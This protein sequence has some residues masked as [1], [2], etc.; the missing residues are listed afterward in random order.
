[1]KKIVIIVAIA[2][3]VTIAPSFV[4]DMFV[5]TV[6]ASNT[7]GT[8]DAT[9]KY[10]WGENIGWINF[11]TT[12]G[13]I[14]ITDS[15][16]TGY[17]WSEN[18]G[19]LPLNCSNDNSCNAVNYKIS[20]NG[21]GVLS[22][23][24]YSSETGYISFA[25]SNGG[26]TINSSGEFQGYAWGENIGWIVFN[27][28]TTNSC[29]TA[30]YKVKTDWRPQNVRPA[31]NNTL[32]DDGDGKIDYPSDSACDSLGG[33]TE[34]PVEG[35][36]VIV[37]GGGAT[38]TSGS[39]TSSGTSTSSTSSTPSTTPGTT[40]STAV[41]GGDQAISINDNAQE[42]SDRNVT[43]FLSGDTNAKTVW[44]SE[45][46]DF[47]EGLRVPYTAPSTKIQFIISEDEGTKTIFAKFC[48]AERQC[49]RV[50]SDSISFKRKT[51]IVKLPP[52]EVKPVF[53]VPAPV[54]EEPAEPVKPTVKPIIRPFAKPI[55][56][57]TVVKPIV[58]VPEPV[59]V[60]P[61]QPAEQA[62]PIIGPVRPA[63]EEPQVAE[64]TVEPTVEQTQPAETVATEP[65][66]GP[67]QPVIEPVQPTIEPVIEP[68]APAETK[69]VEPAIVGPTIPAEA[70]PAMQGTWT[71]VSQQPVGGF[72]PTPIPEAVTVFVDK[73]PEL[74]STFSSIGV[75][76]LPDIENLKNVQFNLPGLAEA[77]GLP[78]GVPVSSLSV[79]NKK[80]LPS[81]V[82]FA[83]TGNGF[84]D[85][86]STLNISEKGESRQRISSI[87][88][89]PMELVI[90]TDKPV[91]K[92]TGYVIYKTRKPQ[93]T[94]SSFVD[95]LISSMFSTA[96][97]SD[98]AN[99][100]ER[101]VLE[102]FEYTDPD[103]DGIYTANIT[104]PLVGGEFEIITV[105]DYKDPTLVAKEVRLTTVIDPEGYI[106]EKTGDKETRIPGA[107]ASLYWL[108]PDTKQYELWA[109]EKYQQENP[110][111]TGMSGAYS[112]LAPEGM[113]YIK[114]EAPGYL[115]Y[116]GKPF[117]LKKDN[118]IHTNIELKNKYW[119]L[120]I[121]DWRTVLLIILTILVLYN[122]YRDRMREAFFKKSQAIKA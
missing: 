2:L 26:V 52:P 4:S 16:M 7:D 9:S 24:S 54:V 19:W 27:C 33:G 102:K 113:Y 83:K 72:S 14:H 29:G 58:G 89:K 13:N 95:R 65:I 107:I 69:P 49:S 60:E 91:K 71:L 117:Q 10:A 61:T 66:I 100:E 88:G 51:S 84:I 59:A 77:A 12:E 63:V 106:Y 17:A 74:K 109:A 15:A 110:Q 31:C 34:L 76:S 81:E 87:A 55:A 103:G 67:V 121:L 62:E 6:F 48:T 118:G 30:D 98:E 93:G 70:P 23:Y 75:N 78:K 112:F 105:M 119:W 50:V 43:L 114:V 35:T 96:E 20:N 73:F 45:K 53:E 85:V 82:V 18:L 42:T 36:V 115:D 68:T 122:L 90:K 11:G 21:N 5:S 41:T 111:T 101:M 28:A 92:I 32:D 64:P 37:P 39:G 38:I 44:I 1:M 3:I 47:P 108:N 57:Q 22:G 56:R 104:T 97:A 86:N 120:E 116:N 40:P 80:L 99:I 94:S 8:I 46:P 25:P 79:E